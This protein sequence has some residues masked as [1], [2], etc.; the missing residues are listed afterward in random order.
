MSATEYNTY[1]RAEWEM[2]V[3]NPARARASLA[4][5]DGIK[6]GRVLDVG[7]GAG[8]ELVPFVAG[9]DVLGVGIDL[10]PQAGQVGRDLF[11]A[12]DCAGRVA[13]MRASA[14]SLPFGSQI[15]DVIICRVVLPYTD[16][17][18]AL[19][20][21][22]R[23]LSSEGVCLLKIHHARFYLKELLD[24]LT[25]L[26]ALSAVHA[27]RVLASGA[28][29]HLSG[30]QPRNRLTGNESFQTK[31]LLLRELKKRGLDITGE[32]PDSNPATPS[33]IISS[34]KSS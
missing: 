7:C 13:F 11:A 20:E 22:A 15:F 30:V 16:N 4:A 26:Q 28:I 14:E 19:D 5:A 17:G 18:R 25:S 27:L 31:R 33:F 29:Y 6:I 34:G 24:A 21:I 23:V 32:M 10:A 9:K 3:G 1:L 8:Q 2:F 12:R